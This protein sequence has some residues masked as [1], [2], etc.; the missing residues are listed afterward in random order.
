MAAGGE[1]RE[2]V[3]V[4]KGEGGRREGEREGRKECLNPRVR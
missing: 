4:S 1:V 2:A 3:L